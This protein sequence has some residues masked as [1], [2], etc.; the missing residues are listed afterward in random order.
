MKLSELSTDRAADVLSEV[1]VYVA[2]ITTDE[3]LM[4]TLKNCAVEAGATTAAEKMAWVGQKISSLIPVVL[5]KHKT[6]VFSILA[7]VNGV[8]PEAVAKQNIIKTMTQIRGVVRDK[9]LVDF[10]K[11]CALPE[12]TE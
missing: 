12:E 6:D 3:E 7:A 1:C 4:L 11:S 5:K 10:F 2:N 8:K 9:D